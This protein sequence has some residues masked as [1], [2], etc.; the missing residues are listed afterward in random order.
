MNILLISQCHKKALTET[1]RIL[2][3]FAERCGDRVWQTAI[4]QAGLQTLHNMLRRTARKNT[5]VA[6]YWTHGKNLTDL[7]WIV[8]DS[9]QFNAQGRV[10]TNRTTRNL[11][12]TDDESFWV[13]AYSIQILTA[14]SALL[15]DLGKSSRAFQAKLRPYALRHADCYRHEWI[16]ARLFETMINGCKT[17]SAWL[18]RLAN[19]SEYVKQNPDWLNQLVPN[20][21]N[22]ATDFSH[23]PPLAQM[24]IWLI[25]SH[26]KLPFTQNVLNIKDQK[27]KYLRPEYSHSIKNFYR[28]CRPVEHWV[29]N[30]S[31]HPN[32]AQFWQFDHLATESG[33]WQK[34]MIRWANKALNHQPL[35]QLAEQGEISDPFLLMLTRLC[36]IA[37][38]HN[39]SAMP[40]DPSLGEPLF[41]QKLLANTDKNKQPKQ[42]LDEHLLGVCK[43]GVRFAR[44]L[45]KLKTALPAIGKHKTFT[46]QTALSR[47]QWQNK[48]FDLAKSLQLK[49][50]QQ[51]F[52]GV[53]MASTGCGKTLA[54]ARI[55]YG[56]SDP[57]HGA[58]FT[59]ALGLRVLTLQ[60]GLA[61]R[62]KLSLNEDNL[63]VLVGGS[64]VKTLFE[65]QQ[66]QKDEEQNEYAATGTENLSHW[67]TENEVYGADFIENTVMQRE[68]GTLL[69]E[70]KAKKL[71]YAPIVTCTI[72]H[73][74]AAS[75]AIRG[76]KHIVPMLRL[77]TSDLILDE[78][79][80]FGYQDLPALSRLVHLAGLL[81]G[82]V[83]LSS[84]T[85]TPDFIA[86]L[87]HAYQAGRKIYQRQQGRNPDLP[88]CSAWI[89]EYRQQQHNCCDMP[90][91]MTEHNRFVCLR[92]EKLQQSAVR[93]SAEIIPLP[94]LKGGEN[95]Q[96]DYHEFA[97]HLIRNAVKLHHSH[98]ET[99]PFTKKQLSIGLIRLA[100]IRVIIPLA[101]ALFNLPATEEFSDYKIHLCCYHSRQLLI[102][103]SN[104]EQKLDR[105]LDRSVPDKLFSRPEISMALTNGKARHHIFIVLGS[106]VTEV[107]R[108]H[109]YDWAI[110]DPSSMRSIIQLAGRI[111][112]HRPDKIAD[113]PNIYLLPTNW[114]ALHSN[115]YLKTDCIFRRPGFEINQDYL[116]D[117]HKTAELIT[118]EQLA[119]IQAVPRIIKSAE[120]QPKKYLADLEH[121]VTADLLNSPTANSVNSYWNEQLA[122]RM[123]ANLPIITRFRQSAVENNIVCL[124]DEQSEWGFGFKSADKAHENP[125]DM[126]DKMSEIC[127]KPLNFTS[128][129]IKPWFQTSLN[130]ALEELAE[131][132]EESNIVQVAL[133]YATASLPEYDK[134]KLQ[135]FF[136]EQL[137]FW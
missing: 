105:I 12:R 97:R 66:K 131:Q 1:R 35:M 129:L 52:F 106:P 111:W 5:A 10:P 127:Y 84:A 51:G 8:G 54:N 65:L 24:I 18:A 109:D 9:R 79:D 56:L 128:N 71:I 29:F 72:D 118:A 42:A 125:D 93:R 45:P 70:E 63:A 17:D 4:T 33:K 132:L 85:L 22:S 60:T 57:K 100:N 53:N 47:F 87:F 113:K 77:L 67:F 64:A 30:R 107:G 50:E 98:S 59:I 68:F 44:L 32:P 76:G 133:K 2:D 130:Q 31:E 55:M 39:Y 88:I 21:A 19:W 7:L 99:D 80:D 108:D 14:L 41:K 34:A 38:D 91:F 119:N 94:I 73:L 69:A 82:K 11:L 121:K 37:A 40:S 27:E 25:F 62:E 43:A 134:T 123:T 20:Q 48:A 110:V 102:L 126:T 36:L 95:E 90:E 89:D 92:A 13:H 26:H 15:H 135:W 116:L 96:L 61:L 74:I 16:S 112:R 115:D 81:G 101:Q 23:L 122:N 104:L 49:S 83:L 75:E 120:L 103:R 124:P 28:H 117:T 86:G 58:R 3:Q 6:C 137:G 46:K 136:H 78:P 114:R